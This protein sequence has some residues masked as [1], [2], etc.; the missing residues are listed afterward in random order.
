MK[1]VLIFLLV[2]ILLTSCAAEPKENSK[3]FFEKQTELIEEENSGTSEEALEND[4]VSETEETKEENPDTSPQ[5]NETEVETEGENLLNFEKFTDGYYLKIAVPEETF[6]TLNPILEGR[7]VDF[8]KITLM[9]SLKESYDNLNEKE[10]FESF[11]ND[12]YKNGKLWDMYVASGMGYFATAGYGEDEKVGI[13]ISMDG[14]YSVGQL[15]GIPDYLFPETK[16]IYS[17]L[18]EIFGSEKVDARFVYLTPYLNGILICSETKEC[19]IV[20]EALWD[21]ANVF[22]KGKI[23]QVSEVVA[24]I[25][26]LESVIV[27]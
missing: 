24:E 6:Y 9:Y 23:Y 26:K 5:E 15:G 11:L 21:F 19:I 1:K 20:K 13:T 8:E 3:D 27:G 12:Y 4:G 7:T 18:S 17:E 2:T 10:Q 14:N 16:E 25:G 22:E